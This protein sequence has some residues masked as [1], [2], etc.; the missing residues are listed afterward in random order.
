MPLLPHI[1]DREHLKELGLFN[2]VDVDTCIRMIRE[3]ISEVPIR[4]FY[5]FTVPP[6]LPENWVQPHL[7]LFADKVIPAFR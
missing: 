4:N 6:G 5:S 1:R 2:V 3:Y 7:E